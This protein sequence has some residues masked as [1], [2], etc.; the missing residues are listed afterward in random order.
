MKICLRERLLEVLCGV[1][2]LKVH[3]YCSLNRLELTISGMENL[4]G[5]SKTIVNLNMK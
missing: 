1:V 4:W 3:C 2:G 5:D